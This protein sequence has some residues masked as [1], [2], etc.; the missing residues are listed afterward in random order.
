MQNGNHWLLHEVRHVPRLSRNLISAG[1]LGDEGCVV[2]F[3][4]K[5]WKVSKGSLVVEKCVKVGSLYLCTSHIV[6]STLI[7]SEKNECSGIIV[8]VE[9]GEQ[10]A[11]VDSNTALWRNKLGHMSEKGM[12]VLHSK[13]VLPGL[14]CVNMDFYESCLYGKKKRVSFLK[15]GKDNKSQ[16]LELVTTDVWGPA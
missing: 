13:K 10:I 14:K 2:T 3:N 7:I 8:V 5:N 6:P 16:K 4:D 11:A 1:K 15:T 12:K 9:Q